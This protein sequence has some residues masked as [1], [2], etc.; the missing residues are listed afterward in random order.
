MPS[1]YE[2]TR[3]DQIVDVRPWTAR[4]SEWLSDP[5]NLSA[6]VFIVIVVMVSVPMLI[7]LAVPTLITMFIAARDTSSLLPL[8][9]P[10]KTTNPETNKPGNGIWYLGNMGFDRKKANR[11][12]LETAVDRFKEVWLA[13]DDMRKHLLVLGSTGSGKSELLKGIFFCALCWGSGFFVADGKADNKLPL[14]TFNLARFFGRDDDLLVLN[15]LL[16]GKTPKQIRTARTRRTNKM[17]PFSMADAD[18]IVQMGAN[19]LPKVDGDAKNWQEKGLALWR[20]IVPAICW[21]RDNEAKDISVSTFLE[22][23]AI[24]K[25]EELY[26]KGY[27]YAAR[28][29]NVWPEEFA[30][31]RD[32]IEVGLPGYKVETLLRKHKLLPSSVGGRPESGDQAS[33]VADQHGYRASQLNPALNLLDKTYGHIFQDK[34]SEIDMVDVTL[35]NRILCLLVPSLERSSQEAESLG[36]LTVAC[37]RVMMGKNLGAEIEG[38]REKILESKATEARYPYVIALDELGYYFADGI[39]VMFAQARSLGFAMIAAAQDIEKLTEGS[40]EAEAGAML[41]NQVTK[42]FMRIDDANKTNTMIQKYLE[43]VNVALKSTYEHSSMTGFKRIPEVRLEEIPIA[44]LKNLQSLQAGRAIVNTQGQTF[45]V[46]S[47]YV[48]DFLQKYATQNYHINRF[49]QVRP[50]MDSEILGGF[51]TE[52]GVEIISLPIDA[53]DDKQVRGATLLGYLNG[54]DVLPDIRRVAD[55]SL[56][57]DK[58][59]KAIGLVNAIQSMAAKLPSNVVGAQRGIVLYRA[60]RAYILAQRAAAVSAAQAASSSPSVASRPLNIIPV[61]DLSGTVTEESIAPAEAVTAA[62]LYSTLLGV[63]E[64]VAENGLGLESGADIKDDS[65]DPFDFLNESKP[66]TRKPTSAVVAQ[67]SRASEAPT[68]PA[69]NLV[70]PAIPVATLLEPTLPNRLAVMVADVVASGRPLN[71]RDPARAVG[72]GAE[73][74]R[75]LKDDRGV[76]RAL[77]ARASESKL[78]SEWI[79]QALSQAG[80][81]LATKGDTLVGF[82]NQTKDSFLRLETALGNKQPDSAVRAIEQLVAAQVTPEP[83]SMEQTGGDFDDINSLMNDVEASSSS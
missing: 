22:H 73:Q 65:D 51:E 57:V 26:V 58:H 6:S 44:T 63:A 74:K 13:D 37:L 76:V 24:A 3:G 54:T 43:K 34:Y 38:T 9:Y 8:R 17:N 16:A 32:Y 82:T 2:I 33:T 45:K 39:A 75:L 68:P 25:V 20:G 30:A 59:D 14:D 1:A 78:D 4:A 29:D 10:P 18:T 55:R 66:L 77:D 52:N 60:A 40:R 64:Q 35:N 7:P 80:L 42:I 5:L 27:I 56:Y 71:L 15:F 46:E 53:L 28:N 69:P 72:V 81:G 41:A 49:L 11:L 36:K 67:A 62:G 70:A 23:L 31:L 12:P 83:M 21:M 19:L 48:G 50:L 79:G 61:L 47:F